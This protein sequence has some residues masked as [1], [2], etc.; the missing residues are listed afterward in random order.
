MA[1]KKRQHETDDEAEETSATCSS[2]KR[3]KKYDQVFLSS[4]C[5]DFPFISRSTKG[6]TKAFCKICKSD[7]NIDRSGAYDIKRHAEGKFHKR[8]ASATGSASILSHFKNS[9]DERAEG[10]MKEKVMMA[11]SLFCHLV[12]E[13]NLSLS[14]MTKITEVVKIAFPDSKIAAG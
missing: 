7:F 12:A 14:T 3:T 2:E 5:K 8:N 10:G 4:Y 9:S 1:S 11:E 13:Q 6:N